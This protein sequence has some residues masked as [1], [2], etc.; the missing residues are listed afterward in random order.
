[1]ESAD[2]NWLYFVK[3][4]DQPGLWRIPI[5]R[6]SRA[7][8]GLLQASHLGGLR[9]G[10]EET[11]VAD[12]VRAGFWA[13]ADPGIYWVQFT[14]GRAGGEIRLLDIRSSQVT[15][16]GRIEKT[17]LPDVPGFSVTRDGRWVLYCQAD[18]FDADLI[19]LEPIR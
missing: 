7:L 12:G 10:D 14:P 3:S 6:P 4:P 9:A 8:G 13:A 2:G 16:A 19:L 15:V 17:I 18:Q 1:M 11:L 5:G